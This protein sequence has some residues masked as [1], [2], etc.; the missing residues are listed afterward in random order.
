MVGTCILCHRWA[1]DNGTNAEIVKQAMEERPS[2]RTDFFEVFKCLK[3]HKYSL[4]TLINVLKHF[5]FGFK[6]FE[7][8]VNTV[9]TVKEGKYWQRC[10]CASIGY[11]AIDYN[12]LVKYFRSLFK[13][14]VCS[15]QSIM[16]VSSLVTFR[17]VSIDPCSM[18][19]AF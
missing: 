10:D 11:W 15:S 1:S 2:A 7:T 5:S 14:Q 4:D 8:M 19:P 3:F 9:W 6:D 16:N 13:I 12:S 18:Y 17:S